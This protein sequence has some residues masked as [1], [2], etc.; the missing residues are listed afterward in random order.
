MLCEIPHVVA[1]SLSSQWAAV[2]SR[3]WASAH[4]SVV[5]EHQAR[6]LTDADDAISLVKRYDRMFGLCRSAAR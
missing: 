1:R 3:K 2:L 6:Y 5:A 4:T